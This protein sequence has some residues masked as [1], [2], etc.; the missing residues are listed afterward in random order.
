M[1]RAWYG[2][3]G[4]GCAVTGGYVYHGTSMPEL[5]GW[6]VYGDYCSGRVWALDTRDDACEAVVLFESGAAI[7]SFAEDAAGELYLITFDAGILR[8][9]RE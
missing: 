3:P 1:P 8:L 7:T 4:D 9:A 6:Y 5:R 2:N